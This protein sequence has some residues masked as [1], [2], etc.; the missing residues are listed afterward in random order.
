MHWHYLCLSVKVLE[1][2]MAAFLYEYVKP[3]FALT[4]GYTARKY[5]ARYLL[6]TLNYS[7]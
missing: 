3:S 2:N 5:V 7:D 1:I 6:E 4:S